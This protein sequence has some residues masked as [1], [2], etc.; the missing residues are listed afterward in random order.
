MFVGM[1]S[2]FRER[3][4]AFRFGDAAS[5]PSAFGLAWGDKKAEA[6]A[7]LELRKDL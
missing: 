2:S 1:Y 5:I 7:S 3:Y 6:E 4:Q